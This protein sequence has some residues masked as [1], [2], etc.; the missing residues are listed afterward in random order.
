MVFFTMGAGGP[1][2]RDPVLPGN[3]LDGLGGPPEGGFS[4]LAGIR[5]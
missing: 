5:T 1:R 3:A 2:E 4:W